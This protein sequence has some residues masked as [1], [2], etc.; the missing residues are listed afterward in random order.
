MLAAAHSTPSMSLPCGRRLASALRPA[1]TAISAIRLS[2]S[3]GRGAKR[4]FMR[5]GSSTPDLSST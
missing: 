5:V 2:C 4:G 1:S 3:S